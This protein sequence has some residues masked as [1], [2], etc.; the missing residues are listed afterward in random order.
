MS[1]DAAVS[2]AVTAA[3]ETIAGGDAGSAICLGGDEVS[4]LGCDDILLRCALDTELVLLCFEVWNKSRSQVM[5]ATLTCF[6][7]FGCEPG[8]ASAFN[9]CFTSSVRLACIEDRADCTELADSC[10]Q[11]TKVGC[12]K[13]LSPFH[14]SIRGQTLSCFREHSAASTTE[15]QSCLQTFES[16]LAKVSSP[17]MF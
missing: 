4:S 10:A 11:L 15:Q 3:A 6:E 14:D 16:C 2:E 7:G 12:E 8:A 5:Q 9:D 1:S 17:V 13:T